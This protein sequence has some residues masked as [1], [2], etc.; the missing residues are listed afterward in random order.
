MITFIQI[1]LLLGNAQRETSTE[2]R[3]ISPPSEE[4]IAAYVHEHRDA[5][6]SADDAQLF[7]TFFWRDQCN[8][9]LDVDLL[10]ILATIRASL[11]ISCIEDSG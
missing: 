9:S 6:S 2:V 3:D 5:I 4:K 8:F 10:S 7:I 11:C 1:S